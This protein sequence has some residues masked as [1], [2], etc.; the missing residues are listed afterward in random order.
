MDQHILFSQP[1]VRVSF[2]QLVAHEHTYAISNI[3]SIKLEIIDFKHSPELLCILLG[4]A[5]LF[6]EGA[7]FL[8]GLFSIMA[9]IMG[10]FTTKTDYSLVIGTAAGEKRV[11]LSHDMQY[12][13][14]IISAL[15]IAMARNKPLHSVEEVA[16]PTLAPG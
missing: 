15:E 10:F 16:L 5:L 8:F 6:T 1:G 12:M 9:G 13:D 2:N 14:M 7:L 4:V 11:L 3:T